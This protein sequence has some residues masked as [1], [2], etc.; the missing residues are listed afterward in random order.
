MGS[1]CI[2]GPKWS[3]KTSIAIHHGY[4][5][6]SVADSSNANQNKG[7]ALMDPD[8]VISGDNLRV[9]DE[10]QEVPSLLDAVRSNVDRNV[11]KG[12]YILTGSATPNDESIIHSGVGRITTLSM[13]A[14]SLFES[15]DSP[16]SISI[17]S[18]FDGTFENK[19]TGN[20]DLKHL[21]QL[22]ARGG[23]PGSLGLDDKAA[24]GIPKDYLKGV[25]KNDLKKMDGPQRNEE[26]IWM[27]LR[28]L[29]RNESTSASKN[30]IIRDISDS[31]GMDISCPTID[32]YLCDLGRLHL[33]EDCKPFSPDLRSP[34]RVGKAKKRHF[35]DPSLAIAALG[36][37]PKMLFYDLE[38][39]GFL[40]ESMCD[41]DL[42]IYAK[43]LGGD[44]YH[45]HDSEGYELD[46]VI[47]LEDGRWVGGHSKSN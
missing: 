37:T 6:F 26:K 29:A 47:V 44:L 22:T 30:T 2:E 28:S 1:V 8:L 31:D 16:G 18:M 11:S 21:I 41:R 34:K 43:S 38:T 45:Y 10:W 33:I 3:G 17:G 40:F 35:T 7:L 13:R 15:G 19:I 4:I 20:V 14:M 25:V 23:W 42:D 32:S 27:L 12:L 46:S 36:I 24:M 39:Y 5:I 9:I